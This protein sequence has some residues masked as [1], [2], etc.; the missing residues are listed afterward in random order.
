[1]ASDI[2]QHF[3]DAAHLAVVLADREARAIGHQHVNTSHLLLAMAHADTR[4][5]DALIQAGTSTEAFRKALVATLGA[6][7]PVANDEA[8][9]S[10]ELHSVLREAAM[11]A[12]RAQRMV[13]CQD[14]LAVIARRT[15]SCARDVLANLD[16]F[17]GALDR[18]IDVDDSA[19]RLQS[20]AAQPA[21]VARR[22]A[23]RR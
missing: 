1:M 23:R 15:T 7:V 20:L 12:H 11:T 19:T 17:V 10:E 9:F 13:D 5:A 3:G 22:L 18:T 14:L 16:I 21:K 2:Y 8:S 6:D 4:V